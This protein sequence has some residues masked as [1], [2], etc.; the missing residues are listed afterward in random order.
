[1]CRGLLAPKTSNEIIHTAAMTAELATRETGSSWETPTTDRGRRITTAS[2]QAATSTTR[3]EA[4]RMAT[5]RRSPS[6]GRRVDSDVTLG[7][8]R[9][10]TS[11][12]GVWIS[13]P[14]TACWIATFTLPDWNRRRVGTAGPGQRRAPA[15]HCGCRARDVCFARLVRRTL[16]PRCPFCE[17]S[18]TAVWRPGGSED[19]DERRATPGVTRRSRSESRARHAVRSCAA[20]R[21][22]SR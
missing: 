16:H 21:R 1:M 6:C 17:V 5:T 8:T 15:H 7:S 13:A 14:L 18:A 10:R 11:V 9:R 4:T 20:A 22:L 19:D 12:E 2:T 3:S